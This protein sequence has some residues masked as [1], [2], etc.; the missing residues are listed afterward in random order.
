MGR[1]IILRARQHRG[2][3][4]FTPPEWCYRLPIMCAAMR[5]FPIGVL[6]W[7]ILISPERARAQSNVGWILGACRDAPGER[8]TCTPLGRQPVP[9]GVCMAM[10]A[11]LIKEGFR[12]RVVCARVLIDAD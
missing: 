10:R 8:T 4:L 11:S 9:K 3:L 12:G 1:R 5:Y 7:T 6:A 2:R